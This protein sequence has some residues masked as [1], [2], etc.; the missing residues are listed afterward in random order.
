MIPPL[1][2]TTNNCSDENPPANVDNFDDGDKQAENANTTDSPVV[3]VETENVDNTNI[4]VQPSEQVEVTD[5]KAETANKAETPA[6]ANQS[7]KMPKKTKQADKPKRTRQSKK[8]P[9]PT[10]NV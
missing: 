9:A 6:N 4:A 2:D 10:A 5:N 3:L 1:D 7:K 8:V